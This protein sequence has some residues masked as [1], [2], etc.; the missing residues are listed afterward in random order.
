MPNLLGQFHCPWNTVL[1]MCEQTTSASAKR[2]LSTWLLSLLIGSGAALL[3]SLEI[4]PW[5]C[6][7]HHKTEMGGPWN[8]ELWDKCCEPAEGVGMCQRQPW[9]PVWEAVSSQVVWEAT[10][11]EKN[12]VQVRP[13]LFLLQT[14]V[15]WLSLGGAVKFLGS[16]K[17]FSQSRCYTTERAE[18]QASP[19]CILFSIQAVIKENTQL[20]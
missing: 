3:N 14:R 12:T 13:F 10:R 9:S 6:W 16:H 7:A 8:M 2:L 11:N 17:H 5:G 20:S 18:Q 15:I 4:C 19:W 1:S